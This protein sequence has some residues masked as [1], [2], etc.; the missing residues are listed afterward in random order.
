MPNLQF[1]LIQNDKVLDSVDEPD[2]LSMFGLDAFAGFKI[3]IGYVNEDKERE[4]LGV[5]ADVT[6]LIGCAAWRITSNQDGN[7]RLINA[8]GCPARLARRRL[9]A[10]FRQGWFDDLCQLPSPVVIRPDPLSADKMVS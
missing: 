8:G 9:R 10:M 1:L 6:P 4:I 7:H 5:A 3:V 2:Q